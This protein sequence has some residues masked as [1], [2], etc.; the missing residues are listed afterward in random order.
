MTYNGMRGT[1]FWGDDLSRSGEQK[2][3]YESI[4]SL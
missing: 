3:F 2:C 4:S 1:W